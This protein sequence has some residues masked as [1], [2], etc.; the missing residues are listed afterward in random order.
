MTHCKLGSEIKC[1]TIPE[2]VEVAIVGAG[3]SGLYSAWRLNNE[4]NISDLAILERS[5]RTG[6]RLDSDLINFHNQKKGPDQP[7]IITVKEEQG[8]MR[9]LFDSMDDLMALFLELDLQ[10]EIVPFPMNSGGNN[11]LYFRGE[12]FSV[13][14][15]AKDDFA[16]WSELY[17]LD[18]P[19]QG[20]N[21][22][23]IVNVVFNRILQANPQFNDRP[24]VKGPQFWQN[25]RLECKWNDKGLN[26]WSLWDLFSDMGYSQECITMLYRALGFNGTFLSKMN[27]G[28]AYQLL[29]DFPADAKFRT[30][31]DGFSTLPNALV[32]K[33]GEER[34][35][36][37]T[38]IEAIDYDAKCKEYSLKYTRTDV[39]GSVTSGTIRAEKVILGLPRQALERLF[40]GSNAFNSLPKDESQKIWNTL[41]TATNQPLLKINL[42]YDTPW[43]ATG[44]TGRPSVEFGPNFADLP[45][46]SVY[47]FYAV[48]EPLVA[49]LMYEERKTSADKK[50][51]AKLD[52]INAQK[53][54]R[55]AALT[56]YCDYLN[57][58]F[59]S[60]LQNKGELYHNPHQDQ[61]VCD[62]PSD[63]YPASVGVVEQATA[64]F[65]DIFDTR[66]VPQP[67]LTSARI[68]E[69]SVDFD[70]PM[71]QQFGYGVHQWA[72]GADDKQVMQE[73]TEPLPNLFTCGE[74]FS[75]YQGWVEG[76]LR[77]TDLVLEKGFGLQALDKLYQE[78]N[79]IPSSAAI[80]E[81][82]EQNASKLINEYIDP[83]LS[84]SDA[85]IDE[86]FDR[87]SILGVNLTYFDK[88]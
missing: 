57:I 75:D 77:S 53:Y 76:A 33:I 1:K 30:F 65:K 28:V 70:L 39:N 61:Y 52:V 71:S 40:I 18:Q 19:E 8:G 86:T 26:E 83:T 87:N 48:N 66:Y 22:T 10:D 41:Q 31:K 35:H 34:I 62:V 69:G 2:R 15:A 24:K 55:P 42:Y 74:A 63:M 73:L 5:N 14:D 45:T 79:G 82:Y 64:F 43:W 21:P 80:T 32:E 58:N 6:G 88:A 78:Q 49:A 67:V 54:D 81:A 84:I 20:M 60:A 27:A 47:P 68:W 46:G 4:K 51:Q 13:N 44:I 72:V 17:N 12:S 29:E 85:P 36:L 3:M 59:W 7:D 23:E 50:T 56:I 37:Q 38:E 11:R 25:F 16:I 9:F